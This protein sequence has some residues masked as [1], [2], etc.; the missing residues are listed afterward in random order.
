MSYAKKNDDPAVEDLGFVQ[1]AEIF[2]FVR[3]Q[4]GSVPPVID[5]DDVLADPRRTLRLLCEALGFDF[6]ETM[7]SWPAGLR[8]TDGIWAKHWY[9][10]VERST[11]FR[12]YAKKQV[13]VPERLR[14]V[15]DVCM[16]IYLRLR[17]HRL[18]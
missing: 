5:A 8:D 16:D 14:S 4:T 1:Q 12:P 3:A 9:S 2:D 15:C 11:S 18:H 6:S 10:E 17:E 13:E 7:L